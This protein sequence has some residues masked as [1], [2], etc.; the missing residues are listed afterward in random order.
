MHALHCNSE[1][2][3]ESVQIPFDIAPLVTNSPLANSEKA[4]FFHDRDIV[5][6]NGVNHSN[7]ISQVLNDILE[8][9]KDRLALFNSSFGRFNLSTFYQSLVKGPKALVLGGRITLEPDESS[10]D[11]SRQNSLFTFSHAN[12]SLNK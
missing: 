4:F 6:V 2:A 11:C 5:L 10:I 12:L 3:R 7:D 9:L 1:L 8:T